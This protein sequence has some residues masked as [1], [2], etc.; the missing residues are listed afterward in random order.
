[1]D[2]DTTLIVLSDHGFSPFYRTFAVNSWL[3]EHGYARLRD[4]SNRTGQLFTN[5]DWDKTVAY[6]L[7]INALYLNVQ[8]REQNG[9]VRVGQE[10]D[11]L[12]DEL[13]KRLENEKDSAT[14]QRI[15]VH[16]YRKKE[17]YRG[18]ALDSAP[19]IVLGFNR[20]Y[21][22]SWG[23]ILGGYEPDI[24]TNNTDKWSG[25]HCM[26]VNLLPGVLL[27]NRPIS[28]DSPALVDLA[29][30]I[31]AQF[32]IESPPGTEGKVVLD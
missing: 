22:S 15:I 9:I 6:N 12:T 31:L 4:P 17:V 5:T 1:M 26:D 32:R 2:D 8:G 16:A 18:N 29:P 7:G 14:G 20:G 21:R 27:S 28:S 13:A 11:A 25:D 3:L 23:T 19:D 30:T 24:V 10:A